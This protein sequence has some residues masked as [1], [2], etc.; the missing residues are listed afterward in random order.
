MRE[1]ALDI[2]PAVSNADDAE[3]L[4]GQ[5]IFGLLPFARILDMRRRARGAQ[6]YTGLDN[7]SYTD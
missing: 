2:P 4:A 1:E 3:V 5:R 7:T 6:C